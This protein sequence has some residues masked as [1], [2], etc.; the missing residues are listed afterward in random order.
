[1]FYVTPVIWP[2]KL[3]VGNEHL[4]TFNPFYY[5]LEDAALA[6]VGPSG[7]LPNCGSS[8]FLTLVLVV[9]AMAF[10]GRYRWRVAYWI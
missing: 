6:A 4:L 2:P 1:M 3:L 10:M 7:P 9:A 5:F 8:R